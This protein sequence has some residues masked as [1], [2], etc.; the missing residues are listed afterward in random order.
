MKRPY[1]VTYLRNS[2]NT[3]ENA[4]IQLKTIKEDINKVY[5]SDSVIS[6]TIDDLITDI[7]SDIDVLKKQL[8]RLL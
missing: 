5:D 3:L 6:Q 8:Y 7:S 4:V 2:L 1:K